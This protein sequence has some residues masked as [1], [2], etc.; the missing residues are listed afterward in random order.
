MKR[1]LFAIFFLVN[2]I[3]PMLGTFAYI[4][5][6]KSK[7]RHEVKENILHGIDK[8][9]LVY[10][11]LTSEETQQLLK[12]EHDR[13][14]KYKGEMY[15]VVYIQ[16]S[17]GITHLWCWLD[18]DETQL[19]KQLE[20]LITVAQDDDPQ[21]NNGKM[22]M[23]DTMRSL[24]CDQRMNFPIANTFEFI[25]PDSFYNHIYESRGIEPAAPPP[26]IA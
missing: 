11:H 13:E 2:M 25:Q 22:K 9:E 15:D 18:N 17:N 6:R 3:A 16:Q 21:S 5:Y 24:F 7:V 8:E 10:F 12:W 20:Q 23:T 1:R 26:L 19:N 14:F 4:Q